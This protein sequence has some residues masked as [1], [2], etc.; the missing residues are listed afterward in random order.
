[1]KAYKVVKY[2]DFKNGKKF[3]IEPSRRGTYKQTDSEQMRIFA[4]RQKC[5]PE[6]LRKMGVV[7]WRVIDSTKNPDPWG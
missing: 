6:L 2:K 7:S 1:M 5:L 3:R 4:M